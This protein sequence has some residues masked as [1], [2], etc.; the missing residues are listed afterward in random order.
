M[1]L[2]MNLVEQ[3]S[4]LI[5]MFKLNVIFLWNVYHGGPDPMRYT[6]NTAKKWVNTWFILKQAT[7]KL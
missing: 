1:D 7:E 3:A 5:F 6:I 4:D 2:H